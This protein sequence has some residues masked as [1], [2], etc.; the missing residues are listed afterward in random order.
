MIAKKLPKET[1]GCTT[2]LFV[3][4]KERD[5]LLEICGSFAG[6]DIVNINKTLRDKSD[7]ITLIE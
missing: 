7:R 6:A 1:N 3:S 4:D 2:A 5:A